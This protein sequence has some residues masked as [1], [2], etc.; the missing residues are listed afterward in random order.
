MD[1]AL[2]IA[3]SGLEAQHENLEVISNNLANAST[4]A[5]KKSRAEFQDLPYTVIKQP[6]SPTSQET[7]SPNGIVM[8]SGTTLVGNSKVYSDGSLVQTSR[9]LDIAIQG[10]GFIQVQMPNGAGY[11]YTRDGSLKIN[12]QGQLALA[13]G[14]V[15]QPPITMPAQFTNLSISSDGIV[16]ANTPGSTTS[17]QLGQLQLADFI[18]PDGLQPMGGNLYVST[19]SSGTETLGNPGSQGYGVIHQNALEGSNVNVVEEMV[20][21]IEAQRAF[22]VTSKAVS[23]VDNMMENLNRTT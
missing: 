13:N 2:A 4:T 10:R 12:E 11:A 15:V 8:G 20:N 22:E 9:P 18:N 7:N 19:T 14:Y 21:L 23:A 1:L 5:F 6:G 17:Q 3:K 16:S